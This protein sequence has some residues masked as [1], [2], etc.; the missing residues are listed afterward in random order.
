M[1]SIP[2]RILPAALLLLAAAAAPRIYEW[3]EYPYPSE[4]FAITSPSPFTFSSEPVTGPS[5][6][7]DSRR[8]TLGLDDSDAVVIVILDIKASIKDS[9]ARLDEASLL[10]RLQGGKTGLLK[11]MGGK[12][13]SERD[14]T[15][16]GH[17]GLQFETT[18]NV[19][20]MKVRLFIAN[21][22]LYQ[23]I[24]VRPASVKS[25]ADEDRVLDS[26]KLLPPPAA[27]P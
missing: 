14:I 19:G 23:M 15:L 24:A 1:T 27:K 17:I 13:I 8:Y 5:G 6:P 12:L 25:S 16:A 3:I 4:G 9:V 22:R 26:F 7:M 2:R 21:D 20:I 18:S 10:A 11:A